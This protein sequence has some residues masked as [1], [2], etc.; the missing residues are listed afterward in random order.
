MREG[1]EQGVTRVV[2]GTAAAIDPGDRARRG[3]PPSAQSGIAVGIDARDG[4]VAIR[5][6]TETSELTAEALAR[7]VSARG[8]AHGRLHRRGA[9]R[10]AR[11]APTS[12]APRR[13]Q[14]RGAASSRAA[15]SPALADI[16]RR[17]RPGWPARSSAARCTRAGSRWRRR[18]RPPRRRRD[19]PP[20]RSS[21]SRC[22]SPWP[23][24]P[25]SVS[26]GSGGAAGC[27]SPAARSPGPRSASCSSTS[28]VPVAGATRRPL[29]L[30]DASLSLTAPGGR[31][32][33]ARDSAA[34]WGEVRRFG[35]ERGS[36]RHAPD[37]RPLAARARAARG[38]GVGPSGHRRDRRRDRGCGRHPARPARARPACDSFPRRP[39]RPRAHARER[40]R[41]GHRGRLDPARGRR[42]GQSAAP[43]ADSVAVEATLG[44]KR[45]GD[46]RGSQL[47]NGSARGRLAVGLAARSAPASTCSV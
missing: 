3:R 10:D 41:A 25:T 38:V 16:R 37:P 45:R 43:R 39:S 40:P 9:R 26:S 20:G 34:R 46:P 32:L 21:S 2:I 5:G 18:S 8:G 30:L 35:D 15:A 23:R 6:W 42:R 27:R 17:A 12:T 33:E 11:P 1:L 19:D 7:R 22:G 24:S 13:L 44:G 36:R 29:V 4:Q 14:A 28:A 31:W 47:R